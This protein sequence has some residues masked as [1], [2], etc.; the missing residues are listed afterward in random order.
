[1]AKKTM[2]NDHAAKILFKDYQVTADLL[3]GY[4]HEGKKVI[5]AGDISEADPVLQLPQSGKKPEAVTELL[6]DKMFRICQVKSPSGPLLFG[7]AGIQNQTY[8]DYSMPVRDL[9]AAAA[10]ISDSMRAVKKKNRKNRKHE[11]FLSPFRKS[12]RVPGV[13]ML[14]VFFLRITGTELPVWLK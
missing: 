1:M 8:V 7:F 2:R 14:T 13:V 12:D 3:N 9:Q 4:F 6:A 10:V 11:T 5:H